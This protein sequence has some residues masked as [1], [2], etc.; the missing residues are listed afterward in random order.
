MPLFIHRLPSEISCPRRFLNM[1]IF[2]GIPRATTP[3]VASKNEKCSNSVRLFKLFQPNQFPGR[4]SDFRLILL[5]APSRLHVANSDIHA[6]FVP[7]YSGG[8]VPDLHRVPSFFT[9]VKPEKLSDLFTAVCF[10]CQPTKMEPGSSC[11]I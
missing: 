9:F 8:P 6:T 5:V 10:S 4:F 11:L 7:G 1:N 2:R 3:R